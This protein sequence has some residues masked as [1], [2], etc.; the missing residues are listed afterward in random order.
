MSPFRFGRVF[1][2]TPLQVASEFLNPSACREYVIPPGKF[3]HVST[4]CLQ[5]SLRACV[6]ERRIVRPTC[7]L[8]PATRLF[9]RLALRLRGKP[10]PLQPPRLLPSPSVLVL[11]SVTIP[12]APTPRRA[13]ASPAGSAPHAPPP[14]PQSAPAPAPPSANPSPRTLS[15]PATTS[16]PTV[17]SDQS[18]RRPAPGRKPSNAK[19]CCTSNRELRSRSPAPSGACAACAADGGT[20]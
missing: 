6:R 3:I 19:P 14:L 11:A 18:R 7:V 2:E 13:R 1:P 15:L 16:P 8:R 4:V 10:L 12:P 5:R 9:L 20:K 17:S